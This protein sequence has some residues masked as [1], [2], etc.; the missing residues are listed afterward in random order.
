MTG[1]PI[2]EVNFASPPGSIPI[3]RQVEGFEDFDPIR[4]VLHCDK[5]GTGLVD[6]PRCFSMQLSGVTNDRCNL[7]PS[8]VDPEL[9]IKHAY[10]KND[11]YLVCLVAKHV[12]YLKVTGLR[13]E[14]LSVLG[15][16]QKEFGELKLIWNNLT[17][18]TTYARHNYQRNHH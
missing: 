9:C 7:I 14:V 8:S 2:R 6:A 13:S 18:C 5:P 1:E 16:I 17:N 12:D 11:K 4:E 15:H 3:L 10:R